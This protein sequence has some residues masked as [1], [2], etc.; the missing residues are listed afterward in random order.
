MSACSREEN[1]ESA[2]CSARDR[3]RS[4]PQ[5]KACMSLIISVIELHMS[6]QRVRRNDLEKHT[7]ASGK[8]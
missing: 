1:V 3:E 7:R 6:F 5:G 2:Y 4:A 8:N